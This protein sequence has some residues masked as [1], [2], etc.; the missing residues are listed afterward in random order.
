MV[1]PRR[2]DTRASSATAK[3]ASRENPGGT[4]EAIE[5]EG[6]VPR[7]RKSSRTTNQIPASILEG[8]L[9]PTSGSLETPDAAQVARA[10]RLQKR[11]DEAMQSNTLPS[12]NTNL[13]LANSHLRI[14]G[15]TESEAHANEAEEEAPD[16]VANRPNSAITEGSRPDLNNLINE[17]QNNN[18]RIANFSRYL[19]FY[20]YL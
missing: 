13:F 10:N 9:H 4:S 17:D 1:N 8:H 16:G 5:T 18:V 19:V 7:L 20:V 14:P 2:T 6:R 15:L 11:R 3:Q 12:M